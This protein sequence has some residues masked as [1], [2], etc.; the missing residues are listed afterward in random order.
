MPLATDVWALLSQ[1]SGAS[2]GYMVVWIMSQSIL[3]HIHG[4]LFART[5]PR[6]ALTDLPPRTLAEA[7]EAHAQQGFVFGPTC[8]GIAHNVRTGK[9]IGVQVQV[10][11]AV[12]VDYDTRTHRKPRVLWER[13]ETEIESGDTLSGDQGQWELSNVTKAAGTV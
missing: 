8:R 13:K 2:F 4:E 9:G 6:L 10:E 5:E 7:A 1:P 11:Q 12:M 3:I